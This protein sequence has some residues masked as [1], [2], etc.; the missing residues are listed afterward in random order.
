MNAT[1][2][3]VRLAYLIDRFGGRGR[4]CLPVA[5]WPEDRGRFAQPLNR[6][7]FVL[8]RQAREL[9]V[10]SQPVSLNRRQLPVDRL[11]RQPFRSARCCAALQCPPEPESDNSIL[12]VKL[13][14][15][16]VA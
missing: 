14:R 15:P 10:L 4:D 5:R 6:Q 13:T 16:A 7:Q 1:D 12:N 3:C 8:E 9:Q 2:K 11:R